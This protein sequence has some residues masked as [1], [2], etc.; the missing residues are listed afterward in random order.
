MKQPSAR[1]RLPFVALACLWLASL[2]ACAACAASGAPAW[3]GFLGAAVWAGASAALPIAARSKGRSQADQSLMAQVLA[4]SVEGDLSHRIPE[5][6]AS[7]LESSRVNLNST[8]DQTE[9]ALREAIGAVEASTKGHYWRKIQLAGLHGRFR[10]AMSRLS[11]TLEKMASANESIA[12]DALLS[13]IFS[14]SEKGLSQTIVKVESQA[15]MLAADAI[16]S[17][18]IGCSITASAHSL[19]A[20]SEE[21]SGCL[22]QAKA[23]ADQSNGAIGQANAQAGAIGQLTSKIN[24]IAEQTN[25]LALNAAIEAARAGEAGRG[26]AVVADEVR[27]LADQSRKASDEIASA[28]QSILQSSKFASDLSCQARD[29]LEQALQSAASF[30]DALA[31]TRQDAQEAAGISDKTKASAQSMV[32]AMNLLRLAQKARADVAQTLDGQNID[33]AQMPELE[34]EAIEMTRQ[35]RWLRGSADRDALLDLYDRIFS[36]IE[37]Q[38]EQA[39]R[40]GE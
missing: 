16:R 31:K 22:G 39:L 17:G 11:E 7:E 35:R 1:S 15:E 5:Q 26:F 27:K 37:R 20:K 9:T 13:G 34:K 25:M 18:D 32:V 19:L 8:L 23:T 33:S 2:I 21:L 24:S 6:F 14:R 36:E 30:R 12:K 28:L 29:S 3:A 4:K 38:S 40:I 10:E